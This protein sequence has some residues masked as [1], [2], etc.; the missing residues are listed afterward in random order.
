[1]F[2]LFLINFMENDSFKQH[3]F[4]QLIVKKIRPSSDISTVTQINPIQ[5]N[6]KRQHP[7]SS[8]QHQAYVTQTL[9][10]RRSQHVA[11]KLQPLQHSKSQ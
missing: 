5:I 3:F 7:S 1:M 9:L 10:K 2:P 4:L 11:L 8:L 6:I